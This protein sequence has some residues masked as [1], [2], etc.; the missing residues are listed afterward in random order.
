MVCHMSN[1]PS[2]EVHQQQA[3]QPF[4][5]VP[6]MLTYNDRPPA[7]AVDQSGERFMSLEASNSHVSVSNVPGNEQLQPMQS[8]EAGR[9]MPAPSSVSSAFAESE[10]VPSTSAPYAPYQTFT[11]E[12]RSGSLP[13]YVA[14]SQTEDW[15][16]Y[17][18][19][20]TYWQPANPDMQRYPAMTAEYRPEY[21]DNRQNV[22]VD[23][24]VGESEI[25][26][27]TGLEVSTSTV[28]PGRGSSSSALRQPASTPG[29]S[30]KSVTFHE[31]IAT[32]YAFHQSYGSTSS[33]NS[34][35]ALSPPMVSGG[36]DSVTYQ[37]PVYSYGA[38]VPR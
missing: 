8:W 29:S 24:N 12:Q 23:E 6:T 17:D 31:N 11:A 36:Y 38:P 34:F 1:R 18:A 26:R 33:E 27:P 4:V 3:A 20:Y 9:V 32:E 37:G 10:T 14:A 28:P 19:A 16:Q 21:Y 7:A 30:K 13:P 22:A 25:V 15:K 35:I 2:D 5:Y